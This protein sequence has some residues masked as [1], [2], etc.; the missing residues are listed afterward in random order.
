MRRNRANRMSKTGGRGGNFLTVKGGPKIAAKC[1]SH[2]ITNP[3]HPKRLGQE[4]KINGV[5]YPPCQKEVRFS[6]PGKKSVL[7]GKLKR[8][9]EPTKQMKKTKVTFT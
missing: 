1:S 9:I 6:N 8:S 2:S 5:E 3:N 7:T 4:D